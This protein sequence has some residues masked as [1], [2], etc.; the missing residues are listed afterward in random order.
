MRHY[1]AAW[2]W[3]LR[4]DAEMAARS[5]ILDQ[6]AVA[7]YDVDGGTNMSLPVETLTSKIMAAL[8]SRLQRTPFL[9][10]WII[11]VKR[12]SHAIFATHA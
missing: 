1:F 9:I 7:W 3:S 4:M 12:A 6:W 5:S 10:R 2:S 11:V 8:F